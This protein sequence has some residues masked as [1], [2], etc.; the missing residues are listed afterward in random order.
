MENGSIVNYSPHTA[1]VR[2]D[3][4]QPRVIRHDGIAFV[5]DPR[6]YGKCRPAALRDFVAYNHL[7]R[8]KP[9]V[10]VK[11]P[12]QDKPKQA[13]N[14]MVPEIEKKKSARKNR[15]QKTWSKSFLNLGID[16]R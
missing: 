9:R 10:S 14:Q 8:A 5:P 11:S 4:K 12:K 2:E 1:W 15:R 3:G 7:P 16:E 13:T 6:V